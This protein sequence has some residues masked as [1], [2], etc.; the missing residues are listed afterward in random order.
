MKKF[1]QINERKIHPIELE[2]E[3]YIID[4]IDDKRLF[5]NFNL[6]G[7]EKMID[8]DKFYKEEV[9]SRWRGLY[10]IKSINSSDEIYNQRNYEIVMNIYSPTDIKDIGEEIRERLEPLGWIVKITSGKIGLNLNITAIRK[11]KK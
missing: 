5:N 4:I 11:K 9:P 7:S 6:D 3:D 10:E 8:Y 2:F 1:S